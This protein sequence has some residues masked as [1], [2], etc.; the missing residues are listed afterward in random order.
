M[1]DRALRH[2][3]RSIHD[4]DDEVVV[5]SRSKVFHMVQDKGPLPTSVPSESTANVVSD[6]PPIQ[7]KRTPRPVATLAATPTADQEPP[8]SS[9]QLATGNAEP[10]AELGN[11]G[12]GGEAGTGDHME[13]D[14]EGDEGQ[15]VIEVDLEDDVMIDL[16]AQGQHLRPKSLHTTRQKLQQPKSHLLKSLRALRIQWWPRS[17]EPLFNTVA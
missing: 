5:P 16:P 4:M 8:R 14:W 6:T 1:G 10:T 13:V 3:T 12:A 15:Q 2:P 17:C 9:G 11:Q 7:P